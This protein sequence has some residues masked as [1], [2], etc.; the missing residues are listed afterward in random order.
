MQKQKKYISN[1]NISIVQQ[2]IKPSIYRRYIFLVMARNIVLVLFDTS[3]QHRR[4]L[5]PN[6]SFFHFCY[7]N[8][9]IFPYLPCF[10]QYNFTFVLIYGN[11][12]EMLISYILCVQGKSNILYRCLFCG[13]GFPS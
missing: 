1:P 3:V 8:H 7:V 13:L 12:M 5:Y 2:F 4:W 6:C 11:V 9:R 10:P